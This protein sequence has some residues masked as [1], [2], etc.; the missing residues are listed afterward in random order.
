MGNNSTRINFKEQ[1]KQYYVLGR[2]AIAFTVIDFKISGVI[3]DNGMN[4]VHEFINL[5]EDFDFARKY[6]GGYHSEHTSQF[7][8]R[9]I[10]RIYSFGP[11]LI[12]SL[13]L[14]DYKKI[15]IEEYENQCN[16][17]LFEYS[18]NSEIDFM[19]F[20]DN[21]KSAFK[22]IKTNSHEFYQLLP[23]EWKYIDISSFQ[24]SN[25]LCGFSINKVDRILTVIQIDDD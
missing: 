24:L 21:V 5:P 15:S 13:E 25:Y 18:L 22:S 11:Y 3:E 19:E 7:G 20:I 2:G 4:I 16:Q 9:N 17:M 12:D 1:S 10:S 23:A 6:V 14:D 8:E